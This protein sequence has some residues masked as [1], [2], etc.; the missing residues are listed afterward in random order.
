MDRWT[1]VELKLNVTVQVTL[2]GRGSNRFSESQQY[3]ITSLW[4]SHES[5]ISAWQNW[6][7]RTVEAIRVL[8]VWLK[9]ITGFPDPDLQFMVLPVQ[10]DVYNDLDFIESSC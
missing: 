1:F 8:N 4:Q 3:F 2:Y 9:S 7:P 10:H 5:D 6:C